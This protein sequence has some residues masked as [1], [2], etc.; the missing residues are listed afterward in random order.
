MIITEIFRQRNLRIKSSNPTND[1]PMVLLLALS[2]TGVGLFEA[3]AIQF[4]LDQLLEAPTPKLIL[5]S[6]TGTTGLKMLW[7]W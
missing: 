4:G 2:T 3:N 6:S 7:N 5:P 1:I